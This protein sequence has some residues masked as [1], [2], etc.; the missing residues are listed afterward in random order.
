MHLG[1]LE[2]PAIATRAAP[3]PFTI[4]PGHQ[5]QPFL[6]GPLPCPVVPPQRSRRATDAFATKVLGSHRVVTFSGMT[7][8][9]GEWLQ[10]MPATLEELPS[11]FAQVLNRPGT[12]SGGRCGRGRCIPAGK[13]EPPFGITGENRRRA[14][15]LLHEKL[16]ILGNEPIR[17][18]AGGRPGRC[19]R[20]RATRCPH[21]FEWIP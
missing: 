14:K 16:D 20:H 21:R 13:A 9:L 7:E 10:G 2:K 6:A 5:G 19:A 8:Q 12:R 18:L 17:R 4:R 15:F 3:G 1:I 11:L